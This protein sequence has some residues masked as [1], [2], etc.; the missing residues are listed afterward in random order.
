MTFLPPSSRPFSEL[1]VVGMAFLVDGGQS[2]VGVLV[3]FFDVVHICHFA[4]HEALVFTPVSNRYSW[5]NCHF[6]EDNRP[7][8]LALAG[9][10]IAVG[11]NAE[12][13][14]AVPYGITYLADV[15]D[16]QGTL[17]NL[18]EG[19]GLTCATFV[20]SVFAHLGYEILDRGTWQRRFSDRCWQRKMIRRLRND[21]FRTHAEAIRQHVGSKRFRPEEVAV[22][23]IADYIP[24]V[25]RDARR[26]GKAL[27][28][29][30][31]NWSNRTSH[32]H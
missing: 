4:W 22:G 11:T 1:D 28:K 12:N 14:D 23:G 9:Y 7:T 16:D 18:P 27:I 19:L 30:A 17:I 26:L 2:H 31:A 6:L 5:D 20:M 25:Y 32:L 29:E 24:L 3:R 10:I 15:F 13:V 8:A 21:G